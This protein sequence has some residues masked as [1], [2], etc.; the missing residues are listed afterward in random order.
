M[1]SGIVEE[2]GRIQSISDCA[3]GRRMKI[4]AKTVLGE[5]KI[6]DSISVSGVC[7]TATSFNKDSFS[8]DASFETLRRSKLGNLKV[9]DSVNLER[10]LR[11]SDRLGGHLVSGHVDA[12]AKVASIKSE[13]FSQIIEFSLDSSLEPYF[14]EKGSVTVDGISLTVAYLKNATSATKGEFKFAIAAIPHTLEITTLSTLKPGDSVN[15]ETDLIGKYVL[16]FM[17]TR[18]QSGAAQMINKEGLTQGFLAE[19][20]YT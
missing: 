18:D 16:R 19:H 5:L 1:F 17:Q 2:I 13:G 4:S 7:L 8:I 12:L 9:G 15:I 20:G 3:G 10:A 6:G 14:I 11:L